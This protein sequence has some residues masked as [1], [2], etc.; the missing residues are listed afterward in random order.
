MNAQERQN[1]KNEIIAELRAEGL[2]KKKV[3]PLK[4]VYE[5]W[6]KQQ[7]GTTLCDGKMRMEDVFEISYAW[8][9]WD[10]IRSMT[11]RIVGVTRVEQLPTD[12]KTVEICEKLCQFVYDLG[13]EY[14]SDE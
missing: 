8:K 11:C 14:K 5:K 7:N 13:K 3:N 10:Y 4:E 9:I 12:S 6:F 1:L 2:I